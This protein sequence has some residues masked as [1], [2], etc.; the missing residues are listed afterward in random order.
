MIRSYWQDSERP[1]QYE[2]IIEN[3]CFA[4]MPIEKQNFCSTITLK[5]GIL[6]V[7]LGTPD[8]P[9]PVALRRYLKEFLWDPRVVDANRVWWF[10]ILNFIILNTRPQK[11][12]ALYERVHTEYGPLLRIY[13]ESLAKKIQEKF[14]AET[15]NTIV[16]YAMR[17]GNPSLKSVLDKMIHDDHCDHLLIVPLFPQYA[18]AT[19]G[20]IYEE[21]FRILKKKRWIPTLQ[22]LAPFYKNEIYINCVARLIKEALQERDT[23]P[24][25][26]LLSYHGL[27]QRQVKN[28][29]PYECMCLTTTD[30]IKTKLNFP[31]EQI[32]HT[33][34]SRFGKEEWLTPYTDETIQKLAQD[35]IQDILVCCP[36]FT[37]DCLE[38]IEEIGD[39]NTKLFLQNGGQR[40]QLVSC[41]NDHDFWADGL[42]NLI[43][44]NKMPH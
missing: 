26:I 29:D 42:L 6:L 1:C 33:Y 11:S 10:F 4:Q 36:A 15:Q 21:V 17:Y 22:F 37:M 3:K 31:A 23:P 43:A 16:H 32:L 5:T 30:A 27:P 12:A 13:S 14:L 41:L 8:E 38:T 39:H 34:Q 9:T 18:S 7:Q 28:G 2:D 44:L 19:T 24:E 25:R 40:L 20:S 35:G